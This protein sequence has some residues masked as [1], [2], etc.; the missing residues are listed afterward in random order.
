MHADKR[1]RAIVAAVDLGRRDRPLAPELAEFCALIEAAGARIVG[2][3]V[4]HRDAVDPATL[5]GAGKVIEL[6][7]M[8]PIS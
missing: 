5:F 3:V 4:Q 6:A 1:P 2:E 7:G 8:A